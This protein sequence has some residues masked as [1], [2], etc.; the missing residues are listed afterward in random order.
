MVIYKTTNLVNGKIYIGQSINNDPNYLGSGARLSTAIKK[1]GKENFQKEIIEECDPINADEREI[2]WISFF[3][4]TD[5]NIGYNILEG[6]Q[7]RIGTELPK[8]TKL[9]ISESVKKYHTENP[10]HS[11]EKLKTRRSFVKENNPN[12]GNGEKIKGEKNGMFGK[13]HSLESKKKMSGSKIGS[14][15]S[16]ET[17][18]IWSEQRKGN[19]NPMAGKSAYSIWV[20][21]YGIEEANR[22]KEEKTK[23]MLETTKRNKN[24]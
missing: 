6:G 23:K 24:K 15:P 18:E 17:R 16:E 22:R 12:Y 2:F 10:G 21:K 13:S 8:E 5:R 3:E 20:E 19:K 14:T 7:G 11:K 4:S 1:Y 9:K